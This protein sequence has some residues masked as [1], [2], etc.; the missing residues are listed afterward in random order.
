MVL[1]KL[2]PSN[3]QGFTPLLADEND[4]NFVS[5]FVDVEQD[6]VHAQESE[7]SLGNRI[8]VLAASKLTQLE[9][10]FSKRA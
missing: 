2:L 10:F 3:E 6:P 1:D 7:L 5:F 8:R 4:R 9:R